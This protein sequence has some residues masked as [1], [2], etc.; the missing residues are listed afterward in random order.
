MEICAIKNNSDEFN[1]L[2]HFNHTS[3]ITS[4][5]TDYT[6]VII[7]PLIS[8]FGATTNFMCILVS[9]KLN[10]AQFLNFFIFIDSILNL[11]F[12]LISISLSII[13]CGSLCAYGYK[14]ESKLFELYAYLY[15]NNSILLAEILIQSVIALNR[16]LAF[17]NSNKTTILVNTRGFKILV[18]VI[19]FVSFVYYA[20]IMLL[21]RAIIKFGVLVGDDL[22]GCEVLYNIQ[23][24]DL[25]IDLKVTF[26]I[27][28]LIQ[29]L[30][31]YLVFFCI[32]MAILYR[33]R[34][35]IKEKR[36]KFNVSES[37]FFIY[38]R[39]LEF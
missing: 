26:T 25:S 19:L 39:M 3:S 27:L 17:S 10:K 37:R 34:K 1:S 21:S 30:V 2:E 32:D 7:L 29:S 22:E 20:F 15:V 36:S 13:R 23:R 18:P 8:L 35:Y 12:C 4:K 31:F 9:L 16:L 28:G 11:L 5:Y 33:L 38:K 24:I 14:Y 6:N